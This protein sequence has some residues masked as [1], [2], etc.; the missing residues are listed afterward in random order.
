MKIAFFLFPL[1]YSQY[2]IDPTSRWN[3]K[4]D[5]DSTLSQFSIH[6]FDITGLYEK[7]ISNTEIEDQSLSAAGYISEP[8]LSAF[9]D[10]I[11]L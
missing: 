4:N 11:G 6:D 10:E 8:L 5:I 2:Q 1:V 3:L 9:L 7:Y